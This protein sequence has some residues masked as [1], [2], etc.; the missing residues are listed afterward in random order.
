MTSKLKEEIIE[1][2]RKLPEDTTI[3]EIMYHL[4]VKKKINDGLTDLEQGKTTPH[5]DVMEKI[6]QKLEQWQK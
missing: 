2:I 6:K 5:E 1:F 3:D 4:Y